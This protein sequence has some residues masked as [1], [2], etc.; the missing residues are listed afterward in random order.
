MS[1]SP[2][3]PTTLLV[4]LPNWVGDLVMA[5][6]G[7][8]KSYGNDAENALRCALAMVERMDK[9]IGRLV[10]SLTAAGQLDNTLILFM[11]DNGGCAESGPNGKSLGDPCLVLVVCVRFEI[12]DQA[13]GCQHHDLRSLQLLLDLEPRFLEGLLGRLGL[14]GRRL[15]D[16]AAQV[17]PNHLVLVEGHHLA[18]H[19]L[20]PLFRALAL[21]DR[22]ADTRTRR[23]V[24]EPADDRTVRQILAPTLAAT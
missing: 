24:L 16:A 4:D 7:A 19:D 8:P 6:F 11:S 15:G 1:G 10:D 21:R 20:L 14:L 2:Q 3:L 17:A 9:G 18:V 22:D 13:E 5:I 23:E 12:G